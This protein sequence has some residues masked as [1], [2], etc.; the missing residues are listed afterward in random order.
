[1]TIYLKL[2]SDEDES[3]GLVEVYVDGKKVVENRGVRFRGDDGRDTEISK[4]MFSTFHG[5]ADR[6]WA[7]SEPVFATFDNLE[8]RSG[9]AIREAAG[10]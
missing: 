3:D 7:P 9:K 10:R 8:V 4:L 5:G 6:S 1:M 2:N